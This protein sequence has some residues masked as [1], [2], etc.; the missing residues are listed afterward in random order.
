MPQQGDEQP[1]PRTP[2]SPGA[3]GPAARPARAGQHTGAGG[4]AGPQ[5][6][7]AAQAPGGPGKAAAPA[8]GGHRPARAAAQRLRSL[9]AVHRLLAHP[10]VQQEAARPVAAAWAT[11]AAR[12]VLDEERRRRLEG[13]E[14]RTPEQLALATAARLR[15][16]ARPS[17]RRVINATG[18]VLH[19]NLGRAPLAA[20]AVAAVADVAGAYSTLEYDPATGGRGSRLDHVRHLLRR[21]TGAEDALVVNNNA[22]AVFL[23]LAVLA[24]GREV[25]VSRGQLVEIGGSF[26]IPEILAASGARLVEVGTTNK[27]RL[28]DYEAAIGPETALLLRVHTSNYRIVGFTASVPL[29]DL[30][31][32]GRRHGLPV[33]DDVGSGL[34]VPPAGD[35]ARGLAAEPSVRGSLAAGADLVTFSGDKLLGGPQAGIVAG[36]ADLVARLRRHPLMRALRCDKLVLAALEA[37]LRLYLDPAG[38]FRRVPVL[39]MLSRSGDELARAARRLAARLRRALGDRARV[40]LAPGH[41]QAGG[42]SLPEVPWPTTLVGLEVPGIPVSALAAALRAGEPPVVARIQ[43]DLLWFDPRTLLPGDDRLLVTAVTRAVDGLIT[44]GA[45]GEAGPEP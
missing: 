9:P 34:L 36:R 20:E 13:G 44:A 29:E 24:A 28:S 33:V 35:G 26:R 21:V 4:A 18:V 10:A 11:E 38:A 14:P 22:A 6:A 5:D 37:T 3:S 1:A 16:L 8:G 43:D 12:Q 17:L 40:V 32:L 39:A 23:V 19:T 45:Q 30:V 7:A 2:P 42:G 41:S 15:A 27:T 31:A 25:I